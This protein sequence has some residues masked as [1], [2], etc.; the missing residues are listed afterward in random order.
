MKI[1]IVGLGFVGLSLTSVLSAKGSN[2]LG[3]DVDEKKCEKIRKGIS[4]FFEPEI[5]KLLKH[6]LKKKL[7]ISTDYSL[8]RNS[9]IIFVTVGTPQ[10]TDGSIDLSM[11]ES[12]VKAIGK[13]L[14]NSGKNPII[15][16]KS[17]VTPGTMQKIILPI[18]DNDIFSFC[19]LIDYSHRHR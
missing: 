1:S 10:R 13:V 4:P 12:A 19:L 14:K 9:N 17:T 15:L 8:I 2:V 6:G 16:I 3:I 11:I 5:E 18:L 7:E